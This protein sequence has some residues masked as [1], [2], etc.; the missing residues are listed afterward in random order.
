[1]TESLFGT[2]DVEKVNFIFTNSVSPG[3]LWLFFLVSSVYV[4]PL[5]VCICLLT[6]QS[7]WCL[8][9]ASTLQGFALFTYIYLFFNIC[10]TAQSGMAISPQIL[11]C[12]SCRWWREWDVEIM[13]AEQYYTEYKCQFSGKC[14]SWMSLSHA[15]YVNVTLKI[16]H[17]EHFSKQSVTYSSKQRWRRIKRRYKECTWVVKKK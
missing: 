10:S 4:H 15:C 8:G 12:L 5:Y 17:M 9:A 14:T 16:I 1:M 11:L 2:S 13:L 7:K 6:I 3:E